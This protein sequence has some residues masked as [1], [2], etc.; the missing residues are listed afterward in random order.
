[1][2]YTHSIHTHV[3]H[4]RLSICTPSVTDTPRKTKHK[5]PP[6]RPKLGSKSPPLNTH[7]STQSGWGSRDTR[8]PILSSVWDQN[9]RDKGRGRERERQR[10]E[11]REGGRE[12]EIEGERE[13]ERKE[14]GRGR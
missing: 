3:I 2:A 1:M 4:T 7:P 9:E 12:R 10:K 13:R 6:N 8:V 14:G 11:G 5:L